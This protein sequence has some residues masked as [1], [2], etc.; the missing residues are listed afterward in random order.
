MERVIAVK[1]NKAIARDMVKRESNSVSN[2]KDPV[3]C[4]LVSG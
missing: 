3:Q 4:S 1:Q 2:I